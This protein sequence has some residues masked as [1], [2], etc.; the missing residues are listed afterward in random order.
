MAVAWG[1]SWTNINSTILGYTATCNCWIENT[2]YYGIHNG[3]TYLQWNYYFDMYAD[4][5]TKNES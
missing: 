4:I 5:L 2:R 3:C 1:D